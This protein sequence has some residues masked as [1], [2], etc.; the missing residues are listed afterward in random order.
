MSKTN[1]DQAALFEHRFWL[2]ILGDHSRFILYSLAPTEA[3]TAHVA[4]HFIQVFDRLLERARTDLST[5]DIQTLTQQAYFSAME[6]RN[7]KLNI[8]ARLLE[9]KI[10]IH[11]P[12]TFLNH[13]VNELDEYVR[14]LQFLLAGE[15]PPVCNPLHFHLI[16]LPDASGH[17]DSIASSL[18]PVEKKLVM[19]SQEYAKRFDQ[20]FIKAH[21]LAGYLRTNLE[22]FPALTRFHQEVKLE[23]ML[24][25][26]FL[27][28]VEEMGIDHS[29]LG[30]LSPLFP[31]HMAREE[32]YYLIKLSQVTELPE[33]DCDPTKPRVEM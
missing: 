17:A 23:I 29:L 1:Y 33:P 7:L 21:E 28:E 11:L 25:T 3:E 5:A 8:L 26:K 13:M 19:K 9:G 30:L 15:M 10:T 24:F 31:D 16:W 20:L 12:P 18:D 22:Q 14:I 4:N 27:S 6:L 2:Q 32:C